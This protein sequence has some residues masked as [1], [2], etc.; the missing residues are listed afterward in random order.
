M[1]MGHIGKAK[2]FWEVVGQRLAAFP[3]DELDHAASDGP[4]DTIVWTS[5]E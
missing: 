3:A 2:T 1:T 4:G 5:G